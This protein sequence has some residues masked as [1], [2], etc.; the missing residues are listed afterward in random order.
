MY[1]KTERRAKV[2]EDKVAEWYLPKNSR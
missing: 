2:Y 1:W